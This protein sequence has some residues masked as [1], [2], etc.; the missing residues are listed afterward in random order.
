MKNLIFIICGVVSFTNSLHAT[1]RT[2]SNY[3]STPAQYNTVQAAIN[4]S[5]EGDTIYINGSPTNYGDFVIDRRLTIIGA[6]YD[7]S[8]TD[9]NFNTSVG[10]ITFDSVFNHTVAGTQLMGLEINGQISYASGDNGNIH[11]ITIKRCLVNSYLYVSGNNWLIINNL[12]R[13]PIYLNNFN[14]TLISNNI[15]FQAYLYNSSQSSLYVMNNLFIYYSG[16]Y[17]IYSLTN[18]NIFNN[19]FYACD[20]SA[21]N[22]INN[23][24]NN[25]LSY[26]TAN[27]TL[28]PTG[29]SGTG[30]LQQQ[31][32]KFMDQS[33]IP[34]PGQT[35][36]AYN[37]LKNYNWRLQASSPAKNAGTDETD[38]GIYGGPYPW[39]GFTGMP[40]IPVIQSFYI[41]NPVLQKTD[42]LKIVIKATKQD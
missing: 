33:S 22:S 42:Q 13:Y 36:I 14:N 37:A 32:P 4:A 34:A 38:L 17:L 7:V 11:N 30:N 41:K 16:S 27:Y 24:F 40:N 35:P 2:V 8:G 31:D 10:Y 23:V 12:I 25:N 19:I 15:L 39:P 18:A 28:P 20:V 1:V 26:N 3:A 9:Y 29:N 21:Y 5:T 6:G